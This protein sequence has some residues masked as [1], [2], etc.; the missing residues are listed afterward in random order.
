MNDI[1]SNDDCIVHISVQSSNK[2]CVSRLRSLGSTS[3]SLD[4]N[5]G[6]TPP[7]R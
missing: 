5:S 1:L 3:R 7:S 4:K 6:I 2:E